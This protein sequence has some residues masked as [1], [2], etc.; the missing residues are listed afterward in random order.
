ML[1]TT[2]ITAIAREVTADDTAAAYDRVF[3]PV[4]STPFVL[5]LAEVACHA[6]VAGSLA[7]RELTAGLGPS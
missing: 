5:G 7:D 2:P 6:A 3:A 1:P 4:A